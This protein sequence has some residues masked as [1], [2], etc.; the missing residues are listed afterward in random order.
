[1][2]V[3]GDLSSLPTSAFGSRTLWWWGVLGFILIEGTAFVLA[4]GA[5]FFLMG[6][7]T[8][9]PPN[10]SPPSLW[11]GLLFTVVALLSEIPNALTNRAA[12]AKKERAAQIGLV[13]AC[14][15]GIVLLIVRW[16]EF[17]ALNVRWDDNAYGSIVWALLFIHTTH[18]ITDWGDTLV[19][20]VFTFTHEVDEHRFSDIADNSLYW[21][22]VVI[23]WLPIYLL[24]D[25]A[26]RWV[27]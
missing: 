11:A 10:H 18:V 2:K 12:E 1:M 20:T 19:L 7:T 17:K 5:Y 14:V 21:R 13:T 6:H 22:F 15:L 25:W 3:A 9:W 24:L 23:A 26:P 8:P 27:S 16:F 4:G